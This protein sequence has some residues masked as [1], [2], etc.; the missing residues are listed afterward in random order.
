VKTEVKNK[1]ITILGAA[2]SGIAAA[3]LLKK[4]GAKVY[5]SDAA[6]AEN[7]M[8]EA[9]ELDKAG[10]AYE[11]GMHSEQSL[12]AELVVLSPGIPVRS[13]VV[14]SF[15]KRK[16]PVLSEIEVAWWFCQSPVIAVTGSNGK[17]TTTT[18]IGEML[19]KKY[20]QAIVAGN[21][22]AAFSEYVDESDPHSWAVVEV[23]SFQLETIDDFH[24]KQAVV[25]NF[26]PNHL[27]RY[28]G[29]EDYLKAKWRL[30]KNLNKDDILIY[31]AADAKLTGWA[32]RVECNLQGF[33][34]NG[35]KDHA[36]YYINDAIYINDKKL[37]AAEKIA[38]R[39]KHNYMNVMAAALAAMNAGISAEQIREVLGS[40]TGVEHRLEF[41]TKK[42]GVTF[43]ND[44]KATTVE[45][46]GYALQSFAEPIILITGGQ[47]K[48]S[49]FTKLIDLIKANVKA[50]VLIGSSAGIMEKAWQGLVPIYKEN[51]LQ[52][53][54]NKAV[55]LA[56]T[57][58]TVLL[59]PACASF[60]MFR[61]Y[62]D[63]GRQFKQIV[64]EVKVP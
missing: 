31:N 12:L 25:L 40:F 29:Y 58:N 18:L 50:I 47:D 14:Q 48:G 62:E 30:T 24:P 33:D 17:T 6:P 16:V 54:V 7:K 34:I 53:A 19:K 3:K 61:D 59:S 56:E 37:A 32:E 63:R 39:G 20:P 2:R 45:S 8:K 52:N 64:Q 9:A 41:V 51:S 27:N 60:D 35:V 5:V 38:L 46:L 22:G 49:D 57:N 28:D 36:A 55:D 42:N 43:I 13:D 11:F 10:I 26:A 23:S 21:I 4:H 1:R 15:I 44:S